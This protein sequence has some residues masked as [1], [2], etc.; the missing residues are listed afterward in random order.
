MISIVREEVAT[1]VVPIGAA[2]LL[3]CFRLVSCLLF[4]CLLGCCLLG[5]EPGAE[6]STGLQ[7]QPQAEKR[8]IE[9][10]T[11]MAFVRIPAGEFLMG[12]PVE[13][14]GHEPWASLHRV[15]ISRPFYL[16]ETEVT[17]QQFLEVLGSE[18]SGSPGCLDCPVETVNYHQAQR[19][20]HR[21]SEKTGELFRLPTEAEWEY[22]CRAGT[23][24]PFS[25][26]E[27]LTTDQAN[28]DGRYPY[29]SSPIGIY[30][31]RPTP[32]ASFPPNAFGLFDMHGNVWEWTSDDMCP[33]EGSLDTATV[34]PLGKC[35][36]EFKVIRGGSWI[37]NGDS[38]RC[39]LR[40]THRP[41]DDGPSLGFRVVWEGV[42]MAEE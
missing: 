1:E 25:T 32:V 31:A 7:A 10:T 26:G 19:F 18:P 39:G 41:Q 27:Q 2:R 3:P 37:F 20:I 12:T 4:C 8:W 9:P 24:T 36:T 33:Y 15:R 40:Y 28:F 21:L 16:G 5:C 35:Q 11:G 42:A 22:A 13:E 30:R 14:L 34:N 6:P 17:Q 23:Q 29:P 38:A